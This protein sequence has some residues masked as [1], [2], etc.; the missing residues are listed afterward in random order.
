MWSDRWSSAYPG[1]PNTPKGSDWGSPSRSGTSHATGT[2]L[3]KGCPL[4]MVWV[5][6]PNSPTMYLPTGNL[7]F[8]LSVTLDGQ[9]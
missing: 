1:I 9:N 6:Q 2:P 4:E 7:G 3:G 5:R 8:L